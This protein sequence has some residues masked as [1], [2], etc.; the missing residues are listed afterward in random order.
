MREWG[1]F[2]PGFESGSSFCHLNVNTLIKKVMMTHLTHA[3]TLVHP[4]AQL[5]ELLGIR[6]FV[7]MG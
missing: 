3:H 7:N 5:E 2:L 6:G 1:F 4:S